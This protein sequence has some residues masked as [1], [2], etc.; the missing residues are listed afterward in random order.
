MS[1]GGG[2]FTILARQGDAGDKP[3]E[4][5]EGEY[6]VLTATDTGCGMDDDTLTRCTE[7]FFTTK[8]IGQG[9]GLGLSMVH[10]LA[11]QSGGKLKVHSSPSRGTRFEL[12]L[13]ASA[14]R[15]D[16]STAQMEGRNDIPSSRFLLVDDDPLVLATTA[17]TLREMGHLVVE[18]GTGERALKYL[19]GGLPIDLVITDHAMPGMTGASLAAQIRFAWPHVPVILVSGYA[20]LS[21]ED[22]P[23][24]S[25]LTK[26]YSQNDLLGQISRLL[27][28]PRLS[29]V[30]DC[31]HL[32]EPTAASRD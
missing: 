3:P 18:A 6:V 25:R 21:G 5:A 12:W 27:R 17:A 10:G 14:E 4:L 7:P 24:T 32:R 31:N 26:P 22:A 9:S 11:A 23:N 20:D 19:R 2:R 8:D 29:A 28:H 15:P 30:L 16:A 1:K 13:P